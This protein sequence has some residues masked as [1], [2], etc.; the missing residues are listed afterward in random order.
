MK[1]EDLIL[2]SLDDHIVEPPTMYDQHLTAEQKQFAPKFITEG[3][4]NYWDFDGERFG[5]VGLNAVVGR[6]KS[7]YGME[8]LGLGDMR[9]GTFQMKER[10]DDMNVNGVLASM[11]FPQIVRHDGFMF[12][13][14]K[15][16]SHGLTL[17]KAY[18]DWHVDEWCGSAPGRW[19]PCGIL[20]TWDMTATVEELKRLSKKGVHSVTFSDNPANRGLPSPHD[21]YWDPFWKTCADLDIVI[22]MH[23]G[24]G[25]AAQ[26]AS[27]DAP[28]D[29][30][31][32]CMAMSI[33][34]A[35]AD[36]LHLKALHEYPNLKFAL[37]ESGVGWI[38]YVLDRAAFVKQQHGAWTRGTLGGR[39]PDEIFHDHF[40]CTFWHQE[41]GLSNDVITKLTPDTIC[42]EMDYPHSD[43][44]WPFGPEETWKWI[45]HLPKETVNKMTH[46]NA[47]KN[48]HF[49]PFTAMGG[50]EKC[51]VK[52]LRALAKDVD[53]REVSLPGDKVHKGTG[54]DGRVTVSDVSSLF[55]KVKGDTKKAAAA[56]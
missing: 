29:A 12:H 32:T 25:N 36:M 30:W 13:K 50:R 40:L 54:R 34:L 24:T 22:S 39:T 18:N 21:E 17:L 28:I 48:F 52:A 2:I 44:Q 11:P 9:K 5:N 14:Y 35:L 20:P 46:L 31:I 16:R 55:D 23:H 33:S 51:T 42:Y 1:M 26:A 15:N 27:A 41:H 37:I 4:N 53:V 8:P 10:L 45:G 38:P 49:D 7:E 6:P 19:I 47:M 43:T 56:H 3:R